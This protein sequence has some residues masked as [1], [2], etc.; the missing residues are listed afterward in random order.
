MMMKTGQMIMECNGKV[1]K[2]ALCLLVPLWMS[3]SAARAETVVSGDVEA[4]YQKRDVSANEATFDQYG[5]T[6]DGV[7]IPHVRVQSTGD[8]DQ[9]TFEGTN[10]D[11]N[12]QSYDLN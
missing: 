6:P 12:N 10:V 11:Q 4:G 8:H 9:T 2:M 3:C 1:L 7:D 5:K